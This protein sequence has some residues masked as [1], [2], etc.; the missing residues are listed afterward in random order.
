MTSNN[1]QRPPFRAEHLGSLLRPKE[2]SDKRSEL[3]DKVAIEIAQDTALERLEDDSV[4][5]I[6][7]LQ[8]DLGYHAITDGEFRRHQ[9]W[10][11]F[12]PGLQGFEE[13]MAPGW[14]IFR[15]WVPDLAAF[16]KIS[17]N[18]GVI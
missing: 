15:T 5:D 10:G 12:F 7:K 2:L 3:G 16:S 1:H 18:R 14:E 6:V 17:S 8:L 13:V 4:R 9:F 11:T